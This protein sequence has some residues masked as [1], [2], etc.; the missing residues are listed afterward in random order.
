MFPQDTILSRHSQDSNPAPPDP[1]AKCLPLDLDVKQVTSIIITILS[2]C[3]FVSISDH[4]LTPLSIPRCCWCICHLS[5]SKSLC[6]YNQKTNP[7]CHPL[8]CI[9]SIISVVTRC[10]SFSLIPTPHHF[11][12]NNCQAFD[13]SI[14]D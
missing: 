14:F 12:E 4:V 11:A 8:L 7:R 13:S 3:L 2:D 5:H 9:L 1:E 10:N 6:W